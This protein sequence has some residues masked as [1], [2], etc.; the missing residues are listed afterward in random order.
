MDPP[1]NDPMPLSSAVGATPL[2]VIRFN[3]AADALP[4]E[5]ADAGGPGALVLLVDAAVDR[6]WAA[7]TVIALASAWAAEGRRV[8]LADLHLEDPV[9][10]E[11][12]G[13]ENLDGVV[14]I[15]LYGASLARSARQVAGR[16]F[17]LIPA[18]TYATDAAAVYRHPRWAKLVAGFRDAD[19]MLLLFV[20]GDA[21]DAVALGEWA[22]EAVVLGAGDSALV[23][24]LREA[25]VPLRATLLQPAPATTAEDLDRTLEIGV[26]VPLPAAVL[27]TVAPRAPQA[28]VRPEMPAAEPIE[29]EPAIEPKRPAEPDELP[30]LVE[31]DEEIWAFTPSHDEQTIEAGLTPP[32]AESGDEPWADLAGVLATGPWE[33]PA[34]ER[35]VVEREAVERDAVTAAAAAVADVEPARTASPHADDERPVHPLEAIPEGV[36]VRRRRRRRG[37]LLLLWAGLGVVV[38]AAVVYLLVTMRP[39]WFRRTGGDR[40]TPTDSLVSVGAEGA[41]AAVA[42]APEPAE[43]VPAG[44]ALPYAVQVKAFTTLVAAQKQIDADQRRSAGT[45]FYVSPER[46]QGILY[47]KVRAG[48]L[49]DTVEATALRQALVEAG[50]ID[51]RDAAG[52]WSLIQYAPLAFDLGDFADAASAA[53]HADSLAAGGVPAYAI[54]VPFSDGSSRWRLYAGAYRDSTRAEALRELFERAHVATPPLVERVGKGAG[55]G[56]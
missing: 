41:G 34:P 36:V 24:S 49:A 38:L 55:Q 35:E 44:E 19:A 6:A 23:G 14:D 51:S 7:E 32:D 56:G 29:F 26:P 12:L 31:P 40:I 5:L 20:P 10:H 45:L 52:A 47:Y 21:T 9:L 18:G 11:R 50:V 33:A 46:E 43:P 54:E 1:M 30:E 27:G 2:P 4:S 3:P 22:R 13:E 39:D 16:G 42:A 37:P 25:G 15:F 48:L 28:E 17:Y 53:A 8:V